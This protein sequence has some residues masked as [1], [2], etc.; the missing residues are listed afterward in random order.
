MSTTENLAAADLLDAAATHLDE[1]GWQQGDFG[2]H[3][4]ERC[5]HGALVSAAIM[6]VGLAT[7]SLAPLRRARYALAAYVSKGDASD[8]DC[9]KRISGHIYNWNDDD[10]R[11]KEDV[12][13]AMQKTAIKLRE[14]A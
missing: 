14:Q 2:K 6:N 5:A 13:V 7:T 12:M 4:G 8:K 9:G 1:H 3:G 11:T 10:D